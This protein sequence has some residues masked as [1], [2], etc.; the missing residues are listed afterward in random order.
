MLLATL[1][2]AVGSAPLCTFGGSVSAPLGG[3]GTGGDRGRAGAF[4]DGG[5]P[6][7]SAMDDLISLSK[8]DFA[9]S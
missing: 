1:L 8:F 3:R 4:G 2:I 7:F 6:F 9:I 5:A